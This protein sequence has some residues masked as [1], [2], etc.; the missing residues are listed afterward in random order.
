M[1]E[2]AQKKDNAEAQRARRGAETGKREASG[3]KKRDLSYKAR[4]V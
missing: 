4:V 1:T 2:R 3:L